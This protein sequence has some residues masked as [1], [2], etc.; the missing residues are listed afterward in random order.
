VLVIC[1]VQLHKR[2]GFMWELV[3]SLDLFCRTGKG[4]FFVCFYFQIWPGTG[5]VSMFVTSLEH[6]IKRFPDQFMQ[7]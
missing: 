4:F 5:K 2:K 7:T 1:S 6:V 3:S